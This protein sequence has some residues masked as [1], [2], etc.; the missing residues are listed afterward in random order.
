[1]KCNYVSNELTHWVGRGKTDSE[2]FEVLKIIFTSKLLKLSQCY[3]GSKI[4]KNVNLSS[5]EYMICFTDV[6]LNLSN[7]HCDTFGKFGISYK[8]TKLIPYGANPVL[9]FT[10]QLSGSINTFENRIFSMLDDLKKETDPDFTEY[11]N[12]R[13][14]LSFV[15]TYDYK[16]NDYSDNPNYY[17]R[18]WR[19]VFDGSFVTNELDKIVPGQQFLDAGNKWAFLAFD[20][21]DVE[22]IIIPEAYRNEALELIKGK[23]HVKLHIYDEL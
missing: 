12:L 13:R 15:Q 23:H 1:M 22:S 21:S 6:P 19:I 10:S 8:K 9:Y 11:V 4:D 16:E 18:E 5:A 14:I 20:Y 2:A 17:Q 3:T 7:K